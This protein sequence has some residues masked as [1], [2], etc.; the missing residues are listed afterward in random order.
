MRGQDVARCMDIGGADVTR[1]MGGDTGYDL[2]VGTTASDVLF[3][4]SPVIG[5]ARRAPG[6]QVLPHPH[7][8]SG[9]RPSPAG[10]QPFRVLAAHISQG[11]WDFSVFESAAL[12]EAT[13]HSSS[14]EGVQG[15]C[16]GLIWG[17]AGWHDVQW[18]GAGAVCWACPPHHRPVAP[19][20]I[21]PGCPEAKW[22]KW[23]SCPAPQLQ[24]SVAWSST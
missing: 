2:K 24:R 17:W 13:V 3:V 5:P 9:S 8:P 7:H 15:G 23:V 21:H 20:L 10:S 11:H 16:L 4:M 22:A 18:A 12:C 19:S 1:C 6:S 14:D